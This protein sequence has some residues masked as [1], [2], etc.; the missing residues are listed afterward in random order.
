MKLKRYYRLCQILFPVII[1]GI[2]SSI[3]EITMNQKIWLDDS[4]EYVTLRVALRIAW[5]VNY[6]FVITAIAILW[7]PDS[8]SKEFA[9]I[10]ELPQIAD[11]EDDV[12]PAS[13]N[14][15]EIL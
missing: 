10:M 6:T 8:R 1:L 13:P 11:D 2:G 3:F 15:G 12:V 5:Q 4:L 9:F 14:H 7:K